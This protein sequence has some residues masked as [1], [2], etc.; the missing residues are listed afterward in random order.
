MRI[1]FYN[2][3]AVGNVLGIT[4]L[5]FIFESRQRLK[6]F[7]RFDFLLNLLRDERYDAAIVVD[8]TS[9]SLPFGS[10][11][12][13]INNSFL[14]RIVSF[15]EIYIWCLLNKIN[16][17]KRKIIFSLDKIDPKNDI[18]FGFA[19]ITG[20]FHDDKMIEASFFKKFKG[21]KI[22]HATHFYAETG[23]VAKNIEKTGTK[24]MLAEANLKK[25]DYFNKYLG[26]IKLVGIIPFVLRKKYISKKVFVLRK[27]KCI[28]LGT[29]EIFPKN[30]K[31]SEDHFKFFGT[32]TLH[33][34]RKI[35]A[36]N[37][38]KYPQTLD[39][40]ISTYQNKSYNEKKNFIQR[41]TIYKLIKKLMLIFRPIGKNYH[42]FDI[43]EKFNEYKMFVAPEE[44]IG[45]PS[46]NFI[47][48][49]ACGCAYIG[50]DSFM[51]EDLGLK[52]GVHYIA[53][54]GTISDLDE[55]IRYYQGHQEELEKIARAGHEFVI[56]NFQ[57][58]KI[59]NTFLE[60][61]NNLA[62]SD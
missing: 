32:D 21:K 49:M 45:L 14:I 48:G 51:Y 10:F 33:P 3:H 37:F 27:N 16:P 40:L 57:E 62:S 7:R 53:Y 50:M 28:A 11:G 20:T 15:L 5:P 9:S 2:P 59:I 42:N 31:L 34:M 41:R 54:N 19:Y 38:S 39:S 4:I 22:L 55:K 35:I 23:K 29:L 61:T 8:G 44:D 36:E 6:H 12:P 47:E 17:L 60:V 58:N 30:Y 56:K 18:L 24:F 26:F 46:I 52:K 1:C 13:I 43:V 25:S